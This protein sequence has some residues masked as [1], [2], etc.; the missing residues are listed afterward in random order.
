MRSRPSRSSIFGSQRN[1]S[2]ARCRAGGASGRRR[3]RLEHHLL[4]RARDLAHERRELQHRELDRIADVHRLD[5]VG[6][7]QREDPAHLVVDVAERTRL[8]AGSVDRERLAVDRLDQ[9]VRDD[10]P[11][12]GPQARAVGVEDAHDPRRQVVEAVVGHGER[13]GEPLRL[14]VD[15]ARADGVD[16]AEVAL[17]LRVH[18]RIAVDLAGRREQEPRVVRARRGRARAAFRSSRR[19]A[20]RAASRGTRAGW[21]G[22]RGATRRRRGPRPAAPR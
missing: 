1:S 21:P 9:E 14:V 11:V 18:E 3:E 8:R 17:R 19:R 2:D 5:D 22:S 4:G 12:G 15:R 6:V 20:S 7:E 16:V 10:A 13:L